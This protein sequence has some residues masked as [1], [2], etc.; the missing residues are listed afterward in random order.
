MTGLLGIGVALRAFGVIQRARDLA[1]GTLAGIA[2]HPTVAA[3]ALCLLANL[4]QW[5]TGTVAE[6]AAAR[7][8][9]GWQQSFA[10]E[11]SS[12][13]SLLGSYRVVLAA[14]TREGESI[15]ALANAS[16]TRQHHAAQALARATHRANALMALSARLS[17]KAAANTTANTRGSA[18]AGSGVHRPLPNCQ[19]PPDVLALGQQL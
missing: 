6:H 12:F 1:A 5:H 11:Q 13:A 17:A 9:A 15:E 18:D 10:A 4:W 8:L 14:A 2:A 3:L 19:T 7:R 16:A